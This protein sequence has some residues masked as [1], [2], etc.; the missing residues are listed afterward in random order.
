MRWYL[1]VLGVA[2]FGVFGAGDVM[3]DEICPALKA[4]LA[5]PPAGFVALRGEKT[6]AV[7]PIWTA[8]PF[9][10]EA[11]C[12][13]RG[14]VGDAQHELRCTVNNKAAAAVTTAWYRATAAAIDVCLPGLPN[15]SRYVRKAEAVKHADQFEGVVTSW[16]YDGRSEKVEIELTDDRNFGF[17]SNTMTVRYLKR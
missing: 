6:S 11:A 8:K 16:V 9:L 14:E 4:L 12:E 2:A 17:A 1:R 13:L 3:A 15:G 5:S 7:W 10:A